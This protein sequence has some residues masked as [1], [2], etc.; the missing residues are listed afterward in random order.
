MPFE[1]KYF[2]QPPRKYT[3]EMPR[4]KKWLEYQCEGLV[5]NLFAGKTKLNANEV[6]VD[7]DYSMEWDYCLDCREFVD[8]AIHNKWKFDT[9]VLDPPYTW[10]K[11][12]ELYN[13][14]MIGQFPRLKD[15]LCSIIPVGGKVIIFGFDTVGMSEKRG[16]KKTGIGVICHGGD[17][18]DTLIVME[19]KVRNIK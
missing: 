16:F 8:L 9:V 12:K 11:S 13:G 3:F 6:R 1:M 14:N 19:E 15:D 17:S 5:L 7:A 18:K 4:V 2:S 10:R